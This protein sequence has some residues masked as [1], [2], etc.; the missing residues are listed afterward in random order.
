MSATTFPA[1]GLRSHP[2]R[3]AV[4]TPSLAYSI[5]DFS[6]S[7]VAGDWVPAFQA[8]H[9]AMNAKGGGTLY[10]PPLLSGAYTW[11]RVTTV[12][13]ITWHVGWYGDNCHL[14]MLPGAQ[15]VSTYTGTS[16]RMFWLGGAIKADTQ[17]HT[18]QYAVAANAVNPGAATYAISSV[19][20]GD[21]TITLTTPAD[22]AHFAVGDVVFLKTGEYDAQ[23]RGQD[24]DAEVNEILGVVNDT[25]VITLRYPAAK[26]YVQE[27]WTAGNPTGPGIT[28]TTSSDSPAPFGIC[29]VTDRTTKN[30]AFRRLNISNTANNQSFLAAGGQVLGFAL[31]DSPKIKFGTASLSIGNIRGGVCAHNVFDIFNG[32]GYTMGVNTGCGDWLIEDNDLINENPA[33]TAGFPLHEGTHDITVRGNRFWLPKAVTSN[34]NV[35]SV[36]GRSYRS[37]ILDNDFMN[38]GTSAIV[39]ID[40][41][42][43]TSGIVRGNIFRG[44]ATTTNAIA[45]TP[46]PA[47]SKWIIEG[48]DTGPFLS[49]LDGASVASAA[50][51]TL[52]S[53]T[54]FVKI[55]GSATITTI[56]AQQ[57][58][59]IITLLF[60]GTSPHVDVGGNIK[61]A[62]APFNATSDDTLTL[63]CDGTSWFEVSRSVNP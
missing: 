6:G 55:T 60:T 2:A 39:T 4:R 5:L 26:G 46:M 12:A 43:V 7:A 59:T 54:G 15:I 38:G 48:N 18:H 58:G 41:G 33:S 1:G 31:T 44:T 10:V 52:P 36:L 51:I 37:R 14:E 21:S 9:D 25:G 13:G 28:T 35:L 56:T 23:G 61:V 17:W 20:Q 42:S 47:A 29:N 62:S 63:A 53:S 11:S 24:P 19:A 49:T 22:A 16:V 8:A 40:T 27:Y 50:S 57:V 34:V 32:A 30:V 3:A 45:C